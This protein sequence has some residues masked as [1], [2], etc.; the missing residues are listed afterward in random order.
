M[1]EMSR[2]KVPLGVSWTWFTSGT[3]GDRVG[4]PGCPSMKSLLRSRCGHCRNE[5]SRAWWAF[6]GASR[7]S[8]AAPARGAAARDQ[9]VSL[10]VI[11]SKFFGSMSALVQDSLTAG[12]AGRS[13]AE[14]GLHE[15]GARA[16]RRGLVGDGEV[17]AVAGDELAVL[18]DRRGLLADR[19]GVVVRLRGDRRRCRRGRR[20]WPTWRGRAGWRSRQRR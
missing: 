16:R 14:R 19:A 12:G 20:R 4:H 6:C 5:A 2:R 10:T 8:T 7:R 11:L 17:V 9:N 1:I 3:T 18:L 15:R 13:V